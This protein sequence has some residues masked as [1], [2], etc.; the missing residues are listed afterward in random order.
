[1]T[2]EP[3]QGAANV[4][5]VAQLQLAIKKGSRI[6]PLF[7]LL[8][9]TLLFI[10]Q[11]EG[12][13]WAAFDDTA[14]AKQ[15]TVEKFLNAIRVLAKNAFDSFGGNAVKIVS[16]QAYAFSV[17]ALFAAVPGVAGLIYRRSF[18]R[19]FLF[20]FVILYSINA[21]GW[22][23][24]VPG[25]D[26][27]S[28]ER[29]SE[30]VLNFILTQLILFVLAFRL[31]R[32]VSGQRL[33]PT[34]LYNGLLAAALLVLVA[35]CINDWPAWVWSSLSSK[36][37]KLEFVLLVI[38][39]LYFLL[40]QSDV[41]SSDTRKNIVV[42]LDGTG[43]TTG[44]TEM[45]RTTQTN[46]LKLFGMLKQDKSKGA[47]LNALVPPG[48]RFDATLS[49][50]Y[51]DKQ[52]AFY[53]SG[54][55][56][57]IENSPI[58]DV[59]GSA[60]GLGAASIVDRAYLDVIR[61]YRPGDRIFIFGFSRGAAIARLLAR[62]I[63]QRGA[64]KR[65]WT[66][67]LLGRH[68]VVWKSASKQHDVPVSV[69]GCWDTV[70]AFGVAKT[71]AGIDFGKINAFKDLAIADNVEQAYHMVALDEMRD[72]FVPNLMDPDP[73]TPERIIEVWFSG[74]HSNVGGSWATD[75]LSD[76][77][78]DFL[79]RLVSSGYAID[80]SSKPGDEAWGLYLSALNGQTVNAAA[81]TD[82]VVLQPDAL[83]Q[84]RQ[85]TSMIYGYFARK[86]PLHAVIAELVFERMT[87]SHPAY[88]PQS[89][90][91][92]NDEL[93]RKRDTIDAKVI[94][95]RDTNSLRDG[96]F[97]K[98]LEFKEKLRLTR[99]NQHWLELGAVRTTKLPPEH[100][101]NDPEIKPER[102]QS[103]ASLNAVRGEQ[104]AVG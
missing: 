20:A 17:I 44:Q 26:I 97:E 54:V 41:W 9:V 40:K 94:R 90:F 67:R 53:Y 46:V 8:L 59:L 42:C 103:G 12:L 30:G 47:L 36:W 13:T 25:T 104:N 61:V 32:H 57:T 37:Y 100:L 85:V 27:P 50:R 23:G 72:S 11:L 49:K 78:L 24:K 4:Q 101:A 86:M 69:L 82:A 6:I 77:T 18:W 74:D 16:A 84:V 91:D 5:N 99:W 43:Q 28:N 45:G 88:A 89:L 38:P 63:D 31:R 58:L 81:Y 64:P 93:D 80:D 2:V 75:K 62:M 102:S 66:L 65:L 34:Y 19:Y 73:L 60:T 39:S 76:V 21:S 70:G 55:G 56:N 7:L 15:E 51:Q 87:R 96:E 3:L 52:I 83:G 95:L 92:L 79:L 10:R 14:I 71:I 98:I 35:A 33:L 22:F 48:G 1:M 68:W 29:F